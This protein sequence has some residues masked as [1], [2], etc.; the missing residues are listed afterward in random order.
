MQDYKYHG[1]LNTL[2]SSGLGVIDQEINR[3][4]NQTALLQLETWG[5]WSTSNYT[6]SD[7]REQLKI[8]TAEEWADGTFMTGVAEVYEGIVVGGKPSKEYLESGWEAM[9]K[10]FALG[11]YRLADLLVEL[12][13]GEAVEF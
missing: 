12:Y 7:L 11:G 3:P 1:N 6:R 4:L 2:W 9:M 8:K 5:N 10:Q 13:G